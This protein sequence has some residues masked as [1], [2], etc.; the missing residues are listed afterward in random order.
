MNRLALTVCV[1][2]L[3]SLTVCLPAQ[4]MNANKSIIKQELMFVPQ[5]EHVH[6]S[7]IVELSNGDLLA[8]WFQGSGERTANDVRLVG[9]RL[10]KGEKEWSETFPMG[11]TP[12]MPDCNPVL[13]INKEGKLFLFWIAVLADR[14]EMSILRFKTSTDYL[15]DGPPKWDWQDNILFKP[16]DSFAKEVEAKGGDVQCPDD[17]PVEKFEQEKERILKMS[18]NLSERS[19][20]WMTRI[21]PITLENG[22][23]LLPLYSDG[24]N[25]SAIAISDDNGATWVLSSPI[26]GF[27]IQPALAVRKNGDVVAYMRNSTG[28]PERIW[29]SESKDN[30]ETWSRSVRSEH[31]STASVELLKLKDGRW[32]YVA[33]DT[34]RGR[35]LLALYVSNDEGKTW[36]LGEVVEYDPKEQNRY[37]Y[38]CLIQ[39][40][41]GMLHLTYSYH[42][43]GDTRG[44]S[45][46]HVTIDPSRL[47]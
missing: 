21:H 28:N 17:M 46:K 42:L 9:A 1:T 23:I 22:R 37:S 10:K 39:G 26:V 5:N 19:V 31:K 11:D 3:L 38:P 29:M 13:F 34:E 36:T 14:W 47:P 7:S 45:I 25:F 4:E 35:Y 43:E 6:G 27:G 24:F 41:D 40:K 30:G 20:G 15:G 33:G 18:K 2:L 16:G 32:V 12:Y 8:V 44:K